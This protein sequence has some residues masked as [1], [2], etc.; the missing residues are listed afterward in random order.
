MVSRVEEHPPWD[1]RCEFYQLRKQCVDF[2][3]NLPPKHSLTPQNTQAH[4]SLKTSTPY[5]LVHTICLL[6]QIMLHREYVPFI[7]IR[8]SKPEGPLDPPMFS[9]D[10]YDV[11][12]GFWEDSALQC[13]KSARQIM[14]LVRSCQE[15]N[16]LVETPIVG[17][18]IYTVAFVGVYCLNF[19]WMDPEGYMSGP[20]TSTQ[21]QSQDKSRAGQSPGSQAAHKAVEMIGHMRKKLQMADGWFKTITRMYKYFK[22]IQR[23]YNKNTASNA[24]SESDGSPFSNRHLSLREG[25]AGGGLDEFK[26][27]ERTL[28]D[29]GNLANQDV[30]MEDVEDQPGS[31]R[32]LDPLAD[33]SSTGTAVKSE[34]VENRVD[35]SAEQNRTEG[36]PWNAIN[37]VSGALSNRQESL[38]TP[39]SGQFRSYGSYQQSHSA[40]VQQQMYAQQVT[41]FRPAYSHDHTGAPNA[42]PSLTSP[43]SNTLSTPSQPSPPYDRQHQQY[44]GW[45]PHGVSYPMQPPQGPYAN[46]ISHQH[47]AH[48]QA[49]PIQ[50]SSAYQ[51]PSHHPQQQMP[52]PMHVQ[53]QHQ[54]Q[55]QPWSQMEKEAFLNGLNTRL[56]GDDFAAFTDGGDMA[57]WATMAARYGYGDG[58]LTTIWGG[59]RGAA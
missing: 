29:F 36:G 2:I 9:P 20:R 40:P 17:F 19:P 59:G 51:T 33:G 10:K 54:H 57:E 28:Q 25:G 38:A 13:F 55:H 12:P 8:C 49:T 1:S 14:D 44:S 18:A 3:A 6:S 23:D 41:S 32:G 53:E 22:R 4:I 37:T 52:P 58:W 26:L 48:Q 27:L 31:P 35:E 39:T 50:T 30:E 11:P 7:P 47:H 24:T 16:A 43:G 5:M 46:G 45:S 34:E 56:G 15:W 21:I 42:P